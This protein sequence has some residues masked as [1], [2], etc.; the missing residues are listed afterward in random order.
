MKKVLGPED[1]IQIKKQK[2]TKKRSQAP[3]KKKQSKKVNLRDDWSFKAII[4]SLVI[5]LV[6]TLL[7]TFSIYRAY[8]ST[9]RPIVGQRFVGDLDPSLE[10]K[11]L[12]AIKE[13]LMD[14]EGVKEV[15]VNLK[16]A[17]LRIYLE[18]NDDLGKDLFT[19]KA[20]EAQKLLYSLYDEKLYF[21]ADGTKLQYDFEIYAYRLGEEPIILT[22]YKTSRM[23]EAHQQFLS[24]PASEEMAE[25]LLEQEKLR[26]EEEAREKEEPEADLPAAEEGE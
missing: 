25:Y 10:K 24:D 12:K 14:I 4:I 13:N 6:P 21:T 17:T 1:T 7:L 20:E 3:K 15:D 23:K 26:E 16:T 9:G 5:I 8:R 18:M 19:G 2:P 11:D 22:H